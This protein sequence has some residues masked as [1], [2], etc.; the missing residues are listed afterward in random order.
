MSKDIIQGLTESGP[1]YEKHLKKMTGKPWNFVSVKKGERLEMKFQSKKTS[2]DVVRPYLFMSVSYDSN[3]DLYDLKEGYVAGDGSVQKTRDVKGLD[4]G[5]LLDPA[6]A[7]AGL[8]QF[9]PTVK[10]VKAPDK[11]QK[12]LIKAA[13]KVT[14]ESFELEEGK[15]LPLGTE[16]LR[17]GKTYIKTAQGWQY[18][19]KGRAKAKKAAPTPVSKKSKTPKD[20]KG[21]L[22]DLAPSPKN[23]VLKAKNLK[24]KKSRKNLKAAKNLVSL[25]NAPQ[26]KGSSKI[27]N[28]VKV[29]HKIG[30]AVAKK[31]NNA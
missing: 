28:L 30:K 17:G 26:P 8:V 14:A 9:V 5:T 29:L 23:G 27:S 31:M 22:K 4:L 12:K 15:A 1:A 3:K 13:R 16:R 7:L 20:K 21:P 6:K 24:V 11:S 19:K 10:T 18:Q 25:P 2:G